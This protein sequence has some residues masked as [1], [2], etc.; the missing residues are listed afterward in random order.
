MK[1]LILSS[2]LPYPP[3]DGG[4][5]AT[6]TLAK[7]VADAGMDVTMLS[8]NTSKHFF[9]LEEIPDAIRNSIAIVAVEH[10]TSIKPLKA[11]FNLLFS[12][13]PY[14]SERFASKS[15]REML[16]A[17]LTRTKFDVVQLEGPYFAQ[18]THI[19]R[20]HS[21]ALISLRAHNIEHE[22]WTRR[23]KNESR[24]LIRS[25]LRILAE[26]IDLLETNLL[27]EIDALIPI[28]DRDS[29][30][31]LQ[32]NRSL[33]NITIPAS[34]T[35]SDYPDSSEPFRRNLFFIGALDWAPN[36]EGLEWFLTEV[37]PVL[38]K[39]NEKI[40]F[41]V[42]GRNAPDQFIKFLNRPGVIFHGEVA[43]AKDFI[44]NHGIMAVPLLS[45]SGIRIKILEGMAM[46]KCIVTTTIGAEGIPAVHGKHLLVADSANAFAEN[47]LTL[48]NDSEMARAMAAGA[49]KLIQEKFDTFTLSKKLQDFY[50]NMT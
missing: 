2:K 26:R 22:I 5:I 40:E 12:R 45:G 25:Y 36:R 6:L 28:S 39:E 47:L 7:G 14:I 4:A 35:L 23:W 18:Y 29:A 33:K 37:M 41:H 43:D 3:I 10:N 21:S 15:F 44:S 24:P 8:L 11:I 31:L 20:K 49:R 16:I 32:K 13:K 42:A 1:L 50:K 17:L 48:L 30:I 38:Q 19:I 9:P 46:G 34:I 27:K